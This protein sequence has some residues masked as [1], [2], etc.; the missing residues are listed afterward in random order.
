MNHVQ[1]KILIIDDE[2]EIIEVVAYF[3]A[4]KGFEVHS[5]RDGVEALSKLTTQSYDVVVC[6]YLMPRMDG[7]TLLK[8]IRARK[9]YTSFVFFSGNASDEHEIK[10]IGLGAYALV[11]KSDFDHL[12]EVIVKTLKHNEEVRKI[13]EL[14]REETDDFLAILHSSK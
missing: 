4:K 14:R 1:P 2:P 12:P 13:E 11:P 9:D 10:M 6:D 3:L 5:A 7:I 8:T